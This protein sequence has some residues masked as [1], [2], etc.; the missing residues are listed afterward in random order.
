MRPMNVVP[1]PSIAP[2][3]CGLSGSATGPFI[4][5]LKDFDDFPAYGRLYICRDTVSDMAQ[6]FGFLPPET[7]DRITRER[8]HAIAECARLANELAKLEQVKLV[9][10]SYRPERERP[11]T[12]TEAKRRERVVPEGIAAELADVTGDPG[13][14]DEPTL[15]ADPADTP[16]GAPLPDD[17][18]ILALGS[19]AR[20][21]DITG[22]EVIR[23]IDAFYGPDVRSIEA[24]IA[25]DPPPDK[26]D[27]I[28]EWVDADSN[29]VIRLVRREIA[30]AVER[31]RSERDQRKTVLALVEEP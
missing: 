8:D 4:D 7:V 25:A 23:T 24:L 14:L 9:L 27:G 12:P 1:S 22:L 28:M 26:V 3:A 19:F 29:R 15:P 6:K 5:T 20:L 11:P 10:D 2:G 31:D 30:V 16:D 13:F 18:A 21:D 17:D